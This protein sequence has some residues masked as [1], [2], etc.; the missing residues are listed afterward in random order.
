[1]FFLPR[2]ILMSAPA[3]ENISECTNIAG[4]I[5]SLDVV[6]LP[7]CNS[8]LGA[9]MAADHFPCHVP[10]LSSDIRAN[11]VPNLSKFKHADQLHPLSCAHLVAMQGSRDNVSTALMHS[12]S[13]SR[14]PAHCRQADSGD[15]SA[16]LESVH[17]WL[18][19]CMAMT[20][21][22]GYNTLWRR[23][24]RFSCCG[25]PTCTCFCLQ[26]WSDSVLGCSSSW[27]R[28]LQVV[29]LWR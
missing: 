6:F 9:A 20:N 23:R 21:L 28:Q 3:S 10:H 2:Q 15:I 25:Q 18:L 17:S 19:I 16:E 1:M 7:Y 24:H 26:S 29:A 12:S 8:L 5:S 11:F 4:Q 14:K 13:V 27:L 22:S